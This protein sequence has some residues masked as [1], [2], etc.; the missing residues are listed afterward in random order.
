[1]HPVAWLAIAALAAAYV[2][3]VR[4]VARRRGPEAQPTRRQLW[5]LAGALVSLVV[6]CTWPVA[7]LAAHWSL[8]ALLVQRLLLTLA[9]APLLMLAVP[10]TVLAA[11]TRRPAVDAVLDVA[12]RPPVAVVAFAMLTIGTLLTPAVSAQASSGVARAGIDVLLLMAGFVLWGPVIRNVPGANRPGA[13]GTAGYLFVQSIVPTFPA[14]V[15]IFARHPLYPAFTQAHQAIGLSAL[16][17]QQVAGVVAKVATLPVLWTVAWIALTRAQ[18]IEQSGGD[19]ETLVW[20]DVE[21]RLER[22]ERHERRQKRS[23]RHLRHP[24]LRL[25]RPPSGRL[26]SAPEASSTP[27]TGFDDPETP[28]P[29]SSN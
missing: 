28:P 11:L 2:V 24:G 20:V 4:E 15:Y 17:D 21:R 26:P 18:R 19:P 22:A 25:P 3:A 6:A 27:S 16:N 14:L 1:V 13:V 5:F 8:T 9:A 23:G 7:D 10:A 29:P 12:T